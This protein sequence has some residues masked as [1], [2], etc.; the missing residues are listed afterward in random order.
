MRDLCLL[1]LACGS[2][3]FAQLDTGSLTVSASRSIQLQPDQVV[4]SLS[5]TSSPGSTL[6]QVLAILQPLGLIAVNPNFVDFT[7]TNWSFTLTV[8]LA[9]MPDTV[10]ALHAF[11]PALYLHFS[12]AGTQV[13]PE[14]QASQQCSAAAL[15]S[16]ARAQALK[17]AAAAGL[18]VGPVLAVSDR[19][20]GGVLGFAVPTLAF[21]SGDFSQVS[22][23]LPAQIFVPPSQPIVCSATVKFALK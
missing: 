10:A 6:D 3:A 23:G 13:S 4:F 7:G 19:T 5:V 11:D 18:T 14:L 15:V 8:P 22:S 1:S 17:W 21:R 2:L 9:R 20:V 12:I 16:D